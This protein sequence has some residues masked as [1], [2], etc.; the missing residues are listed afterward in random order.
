MAETVKIKCSVNFGA[1]N[2]AE[3]LELCRLLLKAGYA[4]SI[5]REREKNKYN[6]Y[7]EITEVSK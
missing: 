1:L 6:Y 5:K 2:E 4:V 3:R 7:I